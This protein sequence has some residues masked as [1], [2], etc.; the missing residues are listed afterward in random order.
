MFIVR[1]YQQVFLAALML[2]SALNAQA[3]SSAHVDISVVIP[4]VVQVLQDMHP[5]NLAT[6]MP[7]NN[8]LSV[9]QRLIVF[10]NLKSGLCVTLQQTSEQV[11]K[12][13]VELTPA[14]E[15]VSVTAMENGSYS[16]CTKYIG[17]KNIDLQHSFAFKAN[18]PLFSALRWPIV[19]SIASP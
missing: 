1:L 17:K 4:P 5:L 10:S 15:G 16:V 7:Q 12:W 2:P 8:V 6:G 9:Q 3:L 14:T 13:S 18:S 11:E 19:W